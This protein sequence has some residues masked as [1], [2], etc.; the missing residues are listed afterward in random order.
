MFIDIKRSTDYLIEHQK[1]Y[2][3]SEMTDNSKMQ[4]EQK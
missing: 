4:I 3:F 1:E 2:M